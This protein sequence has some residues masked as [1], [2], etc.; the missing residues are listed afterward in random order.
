M[1]KNVFMTIVFFVLLAQTTYGQTSSD[2]VW[3]IFTDIDTNFDETLVLN[4]NS[5]YQTEFENHVFKANTP[6]TC[7]IILD[8]PEDLLPDD[9]PEVSCAE[10]NNAWY[11]HVLIIAHWDDE[12]S[13][14]ALLY[15]NFADISDNWSHTFNFTIPSSVIPDEPGFFGGHKFRLELKTVILGRYYSNPV[16]QAFYGV[17]EYVYHGGSTEDNLSFDYYMF[18]DTANEFYVDNVTEPTNSL[19]I[20]DQLKKSNVLAKWNSSSY[21]EPLVMVEGFDPKNNNY[22]AAYY[23]MGTLLFDRAKN[24]GRD[25]YILDFAEGGE[26]MATSKNYTSDLCTYEYGINANGNY[27]PISVVEYGN[28][29]VV[30]DAVIFVK[31]KYSGQVVLAGVSMGGVVCRY[32]LAAAE[33]LNTPL[34]VSHFLSIDSPQQYATIDYDLMKFIFDDPMAANG[35]DFNDYNRLE[36]KDRPSILSY[37]CVK[38]LLWANPAAFLVGSAIEPPGTKDDPISNEEHLFLY[39]QLNELNSANKRGYPTKCRNLGVTFSSYSG[40]MPAGSAADWLEVHIEASGSMKLDYPWPWGSSTFSFNFEE[41][42][43]EMSASVNK[44]ILFSGSKLP[45]HFTNVDIVNNSYNNSDNFLLNMFTFSTSAYTHVSTTVIDNPYDSE[46]SYQPTFIPFVSALDLYDPTYLND[47]GNAKLYPNSTYLFHGKAIDNTDNSFYFNYAGNDND[48]SQWNYRQDTGSYP[49]TTTKKV[50]VQSR[51]DEILF[52]RN[53]GEYGLNHDA[54]PVDFIDNIFNFINSR[55][56]EDITTW[57]NTWKNRAE[58]TKDINVNDGN[59]L[60]IKSGI[61]N[62][63]EI[64]NLYGSNGRYGNL[65]VKDGG[66]VIIDDNTTLNIKNNVHIIFESGSTLELGNNCDINLNNLSY[67]VINEGVKL[68]LGE[69]YSIKTNAPLARFIWKPTEV[70]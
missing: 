18:N 54:I 39:T 5:S 16:E 37:R 30:Q 21:R 45:K 4:N 12:S 3:K 27:A 13:T 61:N 43:T 51:F 46:L 59:T 70:E 24:E 31:S 42:M 63:I 6:I 69:S 64:C 62:E 28:A 44:R 67:F 26:T 58:I 11:K 36:Y 66:T 40:S 52:N 23:M 57:N 50:K 17:P 38:E 35:F 8:D 19:T 10:I 14:S 47:D 65:N 32:A 33:H 9:H 56:T 68:K 7:T 53:H 34:P 29:S 60:Y 15:E 22:P 1:K 49:P 20:V 55:V 41:G 2:R 25:A 48:N